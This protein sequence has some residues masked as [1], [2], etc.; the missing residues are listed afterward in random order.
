MAAASFAIPHFL[1]GLLSRFAQGRFDKP[2]YRNSLKECLNSFPVEIGAWTR[3]PG[4]QFAGTT[5][6]GTPGRNIKFDF[7]QS[8]AV[9]RELTDG[10][11]RFRSGARLVNTNDTQVVVAVSAAN[12]AVVQTIGATNWAT[13]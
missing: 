10:F 3:R 13:G 5:R 7:Q 9:T 2:D 12:P 6:G 11:M 8:A 1:G 4:T